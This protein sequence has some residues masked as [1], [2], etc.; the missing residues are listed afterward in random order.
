VAAAS[1]L[2]FGEGALATAV[3]LH[4]LVLIVTSGFGLVSL[5]VERRRLGSPAKWLSP[6]SY[7]NIQLP[8]TLDR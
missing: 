4:G 7:S 5:I 6:R 3:V 1:A 8:R 2:S